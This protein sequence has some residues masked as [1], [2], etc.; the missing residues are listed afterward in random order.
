MLRVTSAPLWAPKAGNSTA[1]YEDAFNPVRRG[2]YR[3]AR[4][5]FAVADGATEGLLSGFWAALLTKLYVRQW[6]GRER[7][8]AWLSRACTDRDGLKAGYL[9]RREA[10]NR[11]VQWYEEPGLAAGAFST[12]TTAFSPI[13][14]FGCGA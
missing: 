9:K 11:P 5:R 7:M 6:K 4:L 10:G 3:G 8:P 2:E 13:T 14:I 1:E 12:L